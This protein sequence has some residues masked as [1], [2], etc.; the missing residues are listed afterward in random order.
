MPAFAAAPAGPLARAHSA[1][2]PSS[3]P[4]RTL[5]GAPLRTGIQ[6]ANGL[7][8]SRQVARPLAA[9]APAAGSSFVE[10]S[11]GQNPEL[12]AKIM[13]AVVNKKALTDIDLYIGERIRK[14]KVRDVYDA[15]E[16]IISVTS[17]RQSAFDRMLCQVPFKGQ[18]L[19]QTTVW[20][21]NNTKHIIDN[22]FVS[23][24]HPYATVMRKAEVF[25]VEFVMRGYLTGSTETSILT[26][27]KN[28]CRNYCGNP[29]PDGL[30]PS[31]KLP[32]NLLTP[33]TKGERDIPIDLPGIVREGLMSQADL[34]VCAKAANELFAF[35]QAEAAK[36][37][38]ILV[39]TKYEFGKLAD[40]TIVLIDEVHTPDSSRY[41]VAST[42][43]ERM[44]AGLGPENIDKE[45]L[46][47]WFRDHCD[48]YKDEILPEAPTELVAELS[49]RYILLYE[50]ITGEKMQFAD[51]FSAGPGSEM[52][53]NIRA[54]IASL[55]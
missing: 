22:A 26:L 11:R 41:W 50:T 14:G 51:D 5:R 27:Y 21:F 20:W 38:L 8:R 32:K 40:G 1:A 3:S 29:L 24:P 15:G 33:T 48:P 43:E 31:Q 46:R 13:D 52:A 2:K 7:R 37:G 16:F 17:D 10:S 42:Y 53:Q 44:A 47:L 49:R 18:V 19:N 12:E 34:D 25:P 4:P 28:G 39:D 45:F 36:R 55:N 23:S 9:Q 30:V 35:G 54:A 6:S